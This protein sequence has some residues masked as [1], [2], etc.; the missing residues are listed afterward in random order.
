MFDIDSL[1]LLSAVARLG[2]FTAAAAELNYTQSAVSRRLA[3]LE[4]SAGLPLFERLPRGVRL[5]AA[6]EL[7]C[8][9]AEEVLERLGTAEAEMAAIR[10]GNGG[11]LRVGSFPTANAVLVPAALGRFRAARPE[12]EISLSE[13]RSKDLLDGL[14]AGDI[15]LA[16]V[17]S[18]HPVGPAWRPLLN[19]P[20]LVALPAGHPMADRAELS[21]AELVDEHWIGGVREGSALATAA[22]EIGFLPRAGIRAN[23]WMAKLG[24][25]A[26]GL[27]VT[28]VPAL[29][30]AAVPTG[31]VLRSL[32]ATAP[33]RQVF[34]VTPDLVAPAA[35]FFERILR[36]Q[37]RKV[38]K[39]AGSFS[40][41]EPP[42]R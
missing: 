3:A 42:A 6:G 7:L 12:V 21:L 27:G 17:S 5:T 16:I 37:A 15:D 23:E 41:V 18:D 14:A 2:S 38:E 19:D 24:F 31:V 22:V 9:R 25:V 39:D 28:L 34:V 29:A 11:G 40:F 10:A 30:A 26:A 1:R 32:G 8:R 33:S 4:Q 20:L 13:G 35:G 36:E